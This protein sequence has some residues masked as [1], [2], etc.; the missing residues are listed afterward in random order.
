MNAR[1]HC[2][3]HGFHTILCDA[4]GQRRVAASP[5]RAV[6]YPV[7]IPD[8]SPRRA[9]SHVQA[10]DEP[11]SSSYSPSRSRYKGQLMAGI[12]RATSLSF[13]SSGMSS[14]DRVQKAI[15]YAVDNG[16]N[17][18]DLSGSFSLQDNDRIR[19]LPS[20]IGELRHL[21]VLP[22][23]HCESDH[24]SSNGLQ[25]FLGFNLLKDLPIELYDLRNLTVLGLQNN[26]LAELSFRIRQLTKLERLNLG[27]NQLET[28]P[29]ELLWLPSLRSLTVLPN[30]LRSYPALNK[31]QQELQVHWPSWPCLL[32][33]WI[34]QLNVQWVCLRWEPLPTLTELCARQALIYPDDL[35]AIRHCMP[36][37][38]RDMLDEGMHRRCI[39]CGLFFLRAGVK[40]ILW[41]DYLGAREL[42][43]L[44][45][46]CSV[47]C[48]EKPGE[49][50][51]RLERDFSRQITASSSSTSSVSNNG[52]NR[53]NN[54]E[55]H[56][57]HHNHHHD[58]MEL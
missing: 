17:T 6:P 2:P 51:T 52:Y 30:P 53:H 35:N 16:E 48:L 21:T 5:P 27:G 55:P 29:G 12:G 54:N 20:D 3:V 10:N 18:V 42:P 14:E 31:R 58:S 38:I 32:P 4:D 13:H 7:L 43:F 44:F 15:Q 24:K 36:G 25:L 33:A 50:Q 11:F 8:A 39:A 22:P 46:F 56:H 41:L 40:M 57:H 23:M 28:L 37:R 9:S 34:V 47:A 49:L 26:Q 1:L 45:R 19:V